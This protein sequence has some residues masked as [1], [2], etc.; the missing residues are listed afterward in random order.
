MHHIRVDKRFTW[1]GQNVKWKGDGLRKAF[2]EIFR[3][4]SPN[5]TPIGHVLKNAILSKQ[6]VRQLESVVS[7]QY[8]KRWCYADK[9]NLFSTIPAS[10]SNQ[11][12]RKRGIF[13][14]PFKRVGHIWPE[15]IRSKIAITHW[16]HLGL[17]PIY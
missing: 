11:V 5:S 1:Q 17:H 6:F 14:K 13:Y 4:G 12:Y 3:Q 16:M 15:V 8:Q 7:K 2:V 9:P 10:C